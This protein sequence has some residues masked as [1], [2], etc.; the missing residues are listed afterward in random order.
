M[1]VIHKW[2]LY[3]GG[4]FCQ[5]YCS[6]L[7]VDVLYTYDIFHRVVVVVAVVFLGV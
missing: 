3:I 5:I 2:S 7:K 1:V 6:L 4:H